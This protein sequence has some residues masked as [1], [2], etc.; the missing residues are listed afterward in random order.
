MSRGTT[1]P[2]PPINVG[3]LGCGDIL[4][5]YMTGLAR[6]GTLVRVTRLADVELARAVT[7]AAHYGI[8]N[9]G[10]VDALWSDDEV[11]L[12]VSL[13]PPI[14]HDK[15]IKDAA[16]AGK[17]VYTEKP[18]SA[19]S[20]LARHALEVAGQGGVVV[21]SAPDTFLGSAA[22]TARA[23]LDRGDIGE[24]VAA[25]AFAPYNRAERR[26]P[27]PGFL[28]QAGAG[29]SLDIAPYHISWLI[30]LLGP[31]VAVAG[32]AAAAQS[33][34]KS[35]L[36]RTV[37]RGSSRN[38]HSCR[39]GDRVLIGGNRHFRLQLRHL[40]QPAAGD[41]DLRFGRNPESPPS[42]LVR[43]RR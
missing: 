5:A 43:R 21:G 7:A 30:H 29:P 22:Q 32:L 6:F 18:L 8:A 40:G 41:R 24:V 20:S 25:A 1:V 11:E 12:V 2:N 17:S 23:V 36:Q 9:A 16:A 14:I 13:T 10:G 27:N 42:Q 39:I 3:I 31:V 4:D 15:I 34:R 28:F 35:D 38:R 26:H 19:T 37:S 33:V